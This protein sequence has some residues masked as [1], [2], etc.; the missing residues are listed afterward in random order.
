MSGQEN[1]A[2]LQGHSSFVQLLNFRYCFVQFHVGA[3]SREISVFIM[4]CKFV[5][6]S[7]AAIK[8]YR[9]TVNLAFKSSRID[10]LTSMRVWMIQDAGILS[11]HSSSIPFVNNY[12]SILFLEYPFLSTLIT[13]TGR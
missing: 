9:S 2:F 13:S 4:N 11:Y 5:R 10:L 7:E 8:N 6:E 12:S 3:Q 1:F